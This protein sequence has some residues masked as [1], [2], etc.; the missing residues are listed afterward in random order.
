M[1]FNI[2]QSQFGSTSIFIGK[3]FTIPSP[4]YFLKIKNL[5]PVKEKL[6]CSQWYAQ[7]SVPR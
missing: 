6:P 3:F 1:K 5:C 7:G 2:F 4:V